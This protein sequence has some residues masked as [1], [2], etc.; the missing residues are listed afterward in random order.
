MTTKS[1]I[2]ADSLLILVLVFG[3]TGFGGPATQAV[4]AGSPQAAGAPFDAV[5]DRPER[6]I[7]TF[8]HA[9]NDDARIALENMGGRVL[10][11]LPLV[12][13]AVV[14][15]PNEAAASDIG[16]LAGVRSVEKDAL[17]FALKPPGSCAPWP[18]CKDDGGDA[19]S[20]QPAEV[21]EWG[22]NRIDADLAWAT[23][24]G[25]GINVAI[26]DTG[27]DK[28]HADLIDNLKGG[29]N[30]VS[31]S[32]MKP[33]DPNKWDDDN[34]HGTHVAGVVAAVD[35]EIGVIGTAPEAYLWAVK[36]LDRNGSGYTSDVIDGIN[37][38]VDNGMRVVNM[39][40]GSGTDVQALHDAV[41]AAYA[42]G[43]VLVAAAGNSGDGGDS[44]NEVVY[45]AKYSSVIAV[46]A[47]AADD[48]TPTWSSEG[49]E[50]ELAAP[51][52]SIRSTWNDGLYN[53]ISGTSMA[54]PHVAGTVA[55]V[56]ATA[57]QAAY[58]T[59]AD[60]LWDPAEVRL[61]LQATADDLGATGHDNFYG[62][63]LVDAEENVTS[64]QTNP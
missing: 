16:T 33:A 4:S 63:G 55:L 24:R 36:V 6:V 35:N 64:T 18:S 25:L 58:D 39:S 20:T 61:A 1:R 13:G 41:D 5:Q 8:N 28:D 30:F 26:I 22:V 32:P 3:L 11:E 10:K 57:M 14:L 47:T 9:V 2:I 44:T 48:S 45:P 29:V 62:Y 56:L 59:D 34:G 23:S 51:G 50:V 17:V 15:L 31:K 53:T 12:N 49:T 46:A 38:A 54:T 37:W 42:A 27:I 21:L 60:G 7:I 19:G 52:V 43:V 40:L